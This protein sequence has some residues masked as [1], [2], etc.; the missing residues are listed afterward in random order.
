SYF[1]LG[2]VSLAVLAVVAALVLRQMAAAV[3]RNIRH[4][5]EL[6]NANEEARVAAESASRSKGEFLANMSHEI[7]TPMNAIV[8]MS[9]LALTTDLTPKQRDYLNK[10]KISADSLLGTI[11]DI[12]DF[13]KIEAGKLDLDLRQFHLSGTVNSVA[14]IV[15][16]KAQENGVQF[17]VET[18]A[19]VPDAL[20][21]DS[22]RIGQV[23]LN[24][25]SNAVKFTP[26]G[27]T[28]GVKITV[29]ER[30]GDAVH[31]HFSVRDS[32]IGLSPEEAARLFQPF[33]QA[34]TSTTR[35]FGGTGLGLAICKQLVDL[36]GGQI[37]V[38]TAQ[39]SSSTG[40]E[41]HFTIPLGLGHGVRIGA[42][43][44]LSGQGNTYETT[45]AMR[46][47]HVLV[48]D[49]NAS[50]RQICLELLPTLGCTGVAVGSAAEGLAMLEK[51]GGKPFDLVLIDWMMP[52]IDG[53]KM[54]HMIRRSSDLL[55]V[56]PKI[57]LMTAYSSDEIRQRVTQHN[58]DGFLVK[59]LSLATM[60]DG[61]NA[62][63][64]EPTD[65]ATAAPA[66]EERPSIAGR[67]VLVV[68]DTDFNQQVA[69]E[70]LT[71]VADMKVTI[72]DNGQIALDLLKT[73]AFDIVLMDIQ[74]PVMD[75][76]EATR[77]IRYDPKHAR[78]PIIA[79]TAHALSTDRD[80]CL[81]AGMNDYISKPFDPTRLFDVIARWLPEAQAGAESRDGAQSGSAA[82][83][84]QPEQVSAIDYA[85]GL[86][87]CYGK[88]DFYKKL[89]RT[90]VDMRAK[91]GNN[92][93]ALLDNRDIVAAA[94]V[95][96]TMKSVAGTIGATQLSETA[97]ELQF[98][99]DA[100]EMSRA[101][102]LLA[103][104]DALLAST[105]AEADALLR[106]KVPC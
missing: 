32:G 82:E 62:I 66:Q 88:E 68:E 23:L 67:S 81:A 2:A 26:A 8:G 24:L 38:S 96:H 33:S 58:F 100:K 29:V 14:T 97:M 21:G 95:A 63:F 52:G 20:V 9:H 41:F 85:K 90:F 42:N 30:Q 104:F 1:Y 7:R 50:A 99:L 64:G 46:R 54:A 93:R 22:T 105:I 11:N 56:Q 65:L 31:L 43:A 94:R 37:G 60:F 34:D 98:A 73:Q 69:R 72:A 53:I 13:S 3:S 16:V 106:E 80:A 48:V 40:S 87:H 86:K 49:D 17:S 84:T 70:L 39:T 18:A 45:P 44:G 74:M 27:G 92:V 101:E 71:D 59:P 55:P 51:E 77:W 89:L 102:P 83:K 5:V 79:M 25:C 15:G 103:R 28:V 78:L 91:E 6:S 10:I 75:G 36:M 12:L 76:Y 35:R 4:H 57:A 19:D 61:I 47:I